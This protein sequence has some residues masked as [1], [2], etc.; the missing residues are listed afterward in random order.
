MCLS[1][2]VALDL[3]AVWC[4]LI[5]SPL[6][7]HNATKQL[8]QLLHQANMF[9][10]VSAL[11][12]IVFKEGA[13]LYLSILI[14]TALLLF[15]PDNVSNQVGL[16]D[17]VHHHRGYIGGVFLLSLSMLAPRALF[18]I[19]SPVTSWHK[20]R[21]VNRSV[22]DNLSTMTDDEKIFLRRFIFDGLNTVYAPISDGI[23]GGLHAKGLVYRAASVG[24]PS[25]W[26]YNLQPIARKVLQRKPHLLD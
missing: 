3:A 11:M 13:P 9:Q 21:L 19:T 15:L 14:F 7:C 6:S 20:D 26:P 5:S 16:S 22:A 12:T 4:T 1:A 10:A 23:M 18:F 17:L 8:V 25:N 2:I 24:N